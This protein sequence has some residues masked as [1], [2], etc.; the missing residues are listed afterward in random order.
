MEGRVQQ[1]EEELDDEQGNSEILMNKNRQAQLQI[2]QLT[3]D[4]AGERSN[5]QKLES[6]RMLLERQVTTNFP[7]GIIIIFCFD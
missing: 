6:N 5:T 7:I 1:L 2:E 4:L 3:T